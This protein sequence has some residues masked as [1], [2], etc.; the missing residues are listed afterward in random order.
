MFDSLIDPLT[1]LSQTLTKGGLILWL[2]FFASVL[3][4]TLIA[5]RYFFLL[6]VCKNESPEKIS[7]SE[8]DRYLRTIE[9]LV[10]VLP[11]LGLLGTVSG[12]I[13]AFQIL[14]EF[15]ASNPRG[16]AGGISRALFTTLAGLMTSLS[17][18]YFHHDLEVRIKKWTIDNKPKYSQ[19]SSLLPQLSAQGF[20]SRLSIAR[21]RSGEF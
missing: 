20:I 16:L 12:M 8:I 2:I 11:L 4:W 3:M 15:G 17:G 21:E 1:L 9:N 18:L 5:E 14:M 19:S 10:Y 6:V 7:S 13:Q